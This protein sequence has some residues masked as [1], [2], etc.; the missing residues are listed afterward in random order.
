MKDSVALAAFISI[1]FIQISTMLVFLY[2]MDD[3]GNTIGDFVYVKERYSMYDPINYKLVTNGVYF[4]GK[5]YYCV[6]AGERDPL[7]VERTEAHEYCHY[8]IDNG[9]WEHFCG[10]E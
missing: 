1:S 8:L 9:E 4:R 10:D 5:D 7:K 6:W 3:F 2:K